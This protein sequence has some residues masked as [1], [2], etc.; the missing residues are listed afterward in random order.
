MDPR[1]PPCRRS[2]GIGAPRIPRAGRSRN[3]SSCGCRW[4][5]GPVPP[6]VSCRRPATGPSGWRRPAAA[7]LPK[8]AS[9][10]PTRPPPGKPATRSTRLKSP[11]SPIR[12]RGPPC[13]CPSGRQ[14]LRRGRRGDELAGPRRGAGPRPERADRAAQGGRCR[15]ARRRRASGCLGRPRRGWHHP[16][17]RR[18]PRR[19][20]PRRERPRRSNRP[21]QA[22]ERLRRRPSSSV[23]KRVASASCRRFGPPCFGPGFGRPRLSIAG[24]ARGSATRPRPAPV[25]PR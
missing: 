6:A 20:L 9:R 17:R 12:R 5:S 19:G 8:R 4:R 1:R 2:E 10:A 13:T 21:P 24:P 14:G 11:A 3:R 25:L 18:A 22:A 15:R 16:G 7:R 23:A